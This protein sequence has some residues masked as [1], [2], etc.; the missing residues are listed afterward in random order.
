M[1]TCKLT[2]VR[3]AS[4]TR[5]TTDPDEPDN[6]LEFTV[7]K[8]IHVP[9]SVLPGPRMFMCEIVAD[10]K[11]TVLW[12]EPVTLDPADH[13]LTFSPDVHN[14]VCRVNKSQAHTLSIQIHAVYL[15]TAMAE[16]LHTIVAQTTISV[17]E[18]QNKAEWGLYLFD[19]SEILVYDRASHGHPMRC[20]INVRNPTLDLASALELNQAEAELLPS[21]RIVVITRGTRG[22]VQPFLALA[23]G[24]AEQRNWSIT[25]VTELPFRDLVK[26]HSKTSRGSIHFRPSGGDTENKFDWPM[27][28]WMMMQ[29]HSLFQYIMLARSER[30]FFESEPAFSYFARQVKPD[31]LMFSFNTATVAQ[32]LGEALNVPICG[33]LLQPTVIPSKQ[34]PSIV[35]ILDQTRP[36]DSVSAE[37][38]EEDGKEFGFSPLEQLSKFLKTQMENNIFTRRVDEM[39]ASNG[40]PALPHPLVTISEHNRPLTVYEALLANNTTLL[41][42]MSERAFGGK[43]KE[44][45]SNVRFTDFIFLSPHSDTPAE[46]LRE[47]FPDLVEFIAQAKRDKKKVVVITFSSMPVGRNAII[48]LSIK[49]CREA[50]NEPR[51]ICV[52][53]NKLSKEQANAKLEN[54]FNELKM[55]NRVF[56]IPGAPFGYL[57]PLC[58]FLILQGGLGT[59]GEALRAGKPCLVTGFLLFDQRFWGK[60]IA[61]MECGPAPVHIRDLQRDIVGVVDLAFAP[62]TVWTKKAQEFALQLKDSGDGLQSNVDAVVQ[63]MAKD[64]PPTTPSAKRAQE[65]LSSFS[66]SNGDENVDGKRKPDENAAY[67]H[68]EDD[69]SKSTA[70][71]EEES[72]VILESK[73]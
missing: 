50:K 13:S 5:M 31:M 34:Y 71:E 54:E 16:G 38:N 58:D 67:P 43:P 56:E 20:H 14:S 55:E 22:D 36:I 59:T 69:V 41:C 10:G 28:K 53:G 44:W 32:I 3:R 68:S 51:V 52:V 60:R 39:R 30:V 35:S 66:S 73:A 29:R 26:S 23:R 64:L 25:I 42:P 21:K 7:F 37:Q 70:D 6:I 40:L 4:I 49:L 65:F 33:F 72:S 18:L 15:K 8:V 2:P 11:Q 1:G 17:S 57:F 12:T 63:A 24:L 45:G 9:T 48:N 27:A 47:K 46:A 19:E 61:D 62:E